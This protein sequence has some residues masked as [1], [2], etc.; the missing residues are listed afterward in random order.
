MKQIAP[1]SEQE[2]VLI[3]DDIPSL[4]AIYEAYLSDAGFHSISA[5]S[6]SEAL[7]KFRQSNIRLV[8]LDIYLPDSDGLDLMREFLALRPT[9]S[10]VMVTADRSIERAVAAMRAGA[11]DFLVKPISA[12]RLVAAIRNGRAAT[13]AAEQADRFDI[14][15]MAG[16]LIA[17]SPLMRE[18]S[19]RVR[20][21]AIGSAPIYIWGEASTG[22][23]LCAQMIHDLSARATGP[24]ITVDGLNMTAEQFSRALLGRTLPEARNSTMPWA[25]AA[26]QARGGTLFLSNIHTL[27]AEA[28]KL[29][30]HFLS[31]VAPQWSDPQA[32]P[33][34]MRVRVI[35]SGAIP[36]FEASRHG[37]FA[38]IMATTMISLRMP[39]L[40]ERREDIVP[41]AEALLA[42]FAAQ[43]GM[44]TNR[45]VPAA[46]AVLRAQDWPG[47]VRQLMDMLRLIVEAHPGKPI[48]IDTLPADLRPH[49]E[50]PPA[51][52][53]DIAA[54]AGMTLA[55]VE[56]LLIEDSLRRYA[57]HV[58]DA[59]RELG[60]AP[61]TIY[62]KISLWKDDV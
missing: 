48:S 10:V 19:A 31:Q 22:K 34:E 4:R 42:R 6:A 7:D 20:L 13:L 46:A 27:P 58:P 52:G 24:F 53:P 9:T 2:P 56:R 5:R 41:L 55:E 39:A 28:H 51:T 8:V 26:A 43:S 32:S 3:V 60:M 1:G 57:G 37:H 33:P 50:P 23:A 18:L 17:F 61:S 21:A 11:Q 14:E 59:A 15:P 29:L 44:P 62:R 49:L 54:F 35:C 25:G 40:R 47:N 30:G 45:L 36:P 16:E 38:P 12:D